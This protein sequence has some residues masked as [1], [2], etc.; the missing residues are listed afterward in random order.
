MP[1][2]SPPLNTLNP[3]PP[4]FPSSIRHHPFPLPSRAPHARPRR[5]DARGRAAGTTRDYED[6]DLMGGG[7]GGGGGPLAFRASAPSAQNVFLGF[8]SGAD[9]ARPG[10]SSGR[11]ASRARPA[12]A[13]RDG[14]APPAPAPAEEDFP[15]ARGLVG[16][17]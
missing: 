14:R 13:R 5:A 4:P 1:E 16:R 8:D 11:P 7:G 17:R 3:P 2:R 10:T 6:R 9:G 12:S 15:S